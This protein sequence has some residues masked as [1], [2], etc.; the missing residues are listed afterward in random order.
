M[1]Y[2]PDSGLVVDIVVREDVHQS[3]RA[4]VAP[5]L[6]STEPGQLWIAERNFCT[7]LTMGA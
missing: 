6:D 4:L 3:E 2:D 5:L 7:R 1:V